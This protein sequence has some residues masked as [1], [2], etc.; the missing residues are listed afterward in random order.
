MESSSFSAKGM[1]LPLRD[2]QGRNQVQ[3]GTPS[4]F[5][6]W[7]LTGTVQSFLYS[8]FDKTVCSEGS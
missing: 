2:P 3:A 5:G 6:W 8:N 7:D 1:E 4:F